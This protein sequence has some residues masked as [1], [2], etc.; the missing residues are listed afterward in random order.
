MP[1]FRCPAVA[2]RSLGLWPGSSSIL[3]FGRPTGQD[4]TKVGH[5][6][7]HESLINPMNCVDRMTHV[8]FRFGHRS[9]RSGQLRHDGNPCAMEAEVGKSDAFE[10]LM[11]LLGRVFW[12]IDKPVPLCGSGRLHQRHKILVERGG[13]NP[14]SLGIKADR[15][16][17]QIDIAKRHGGFREAAPLTH[18]HKPAI[19]HPG[20]SG[21]QRLFDFRALFVG[22]LGFLFRGCSFEAEPHARVG[23]DE[24]SP[25]GLLQDRGVQ[26]QL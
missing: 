4:R 1:G 9:P 21:F 12:Q 2:R 16:G 10:K 11:P 5:V 20:I 19:P 22:D 3:N 15:F 25:H 23:V 6:N 8:G 13:M 18:C 26:R 7:R 24:A 14:A 17:L